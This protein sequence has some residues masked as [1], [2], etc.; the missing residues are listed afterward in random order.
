MI[1]E[2]LRKR[3]L[4]GRMRPDF[5][6]RGSV[7][8]S[9]Y[10]AVVCRTAGNEESAPCQQVL[11]R[12]KVKTQMKPFGQILYSSNIGFAFDMVY[13]VLQRGGKER[14]NLGGLQEQTTNTMLM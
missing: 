12:P 9:F 14:M 13:Q 8:S 11:Y 3:S 2:Y 4:D 6:S 1:D 10:N 5:S 7:K